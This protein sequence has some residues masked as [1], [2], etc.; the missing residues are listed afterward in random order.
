MIIVIFSFPIKLDPSRSFQALEICCLAVTL[1]AVQTVH[2]ECLDQVS[3][4]FGLLVCFPPLLS[5]VF[6]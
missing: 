5:V 2:R 1:I 3:L 6:S 4:P